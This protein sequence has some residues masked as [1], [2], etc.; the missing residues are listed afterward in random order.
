MLSIY[1]QDLLTGLVRLVPSQRPEESV[2]LI[3]VDG[4]VLAVYQQSAT[5]T[6]R[7][8]TES[9]SMILPKVN[10]S[11]YAYQFS[12]AF[13]RLVLAIFEQKKTISG[14]KIATQLVLNTIDEIR[15]KNEVSIVH[16]AWPSAEAFILVPG[17]GLPARQQLFWSQN[18]VMIL[19]NLARWSEPEC[20]LTVYTGDVAGSAWSE[21]H[22]I[23]SYDFLCE[24]IFSRY[25]DL[26]GESLVRRLEDQLSTYSRTQAWKINFLG[27]TVEDTHSFSSEAERSHAYQT[28]LQIAQR[29]MKT[30]VGE[31]L[32]IEAVQ[33]AYLSLPAEFQNSL[34]KNAILKNFIQ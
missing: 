13:V 5:G 4:T 26:A 18:Q 3:Y 7:Y 27:R 30:V 10:A 1:Q 22:L 6:V 19:P 11:L 23:L 20:S 8:A 14:Q 15:K 2:N 12:S 17:H 21:N 9:R 16:L 33:S 24:R 28:L 29:Q 25:S 34:Q 31:K 32:F